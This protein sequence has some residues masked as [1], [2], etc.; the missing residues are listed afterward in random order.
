M[1]TWKDLRIGIKLSVGFGILL[2]LLGVVTFV[3]F[4]G[5]KK[6]SLAMHT[7]ADKDAPVVDVSMEMQRALTDAQTAMDEFMAATSVV[8]SDDEK[9]LS[10][11]EARYQ[12]ALGDFD[13][14][15]GAIM[16]GG[17]PKAG[18]VVQKTEDKELIQKITAADTL[19]NDKFQVAAGEL[20]KTGKALLKAKAVRA[21]AML[22]SEQAYTEIYNDAGGVE[23]MIATEMHKRMAADSGEDIQRF[24]SQL[25]MA[26]EIK[27]AIARTRIALEEYVQSVDPT[28]LDQLDKEYKGFISL[29]DT[30][31]GALLDGGTVD[32]Q[33]IA[34]LNEDKIRAAVSE[35]DQN[36]DV[37]QQAAANLMGA[38]RDILAKVAI[39]NKAMANFDRYGDEAAALLG[40]VE[41]YV[42]GE[43]AAAKASGAASEK[44]AVNISL[45]V[46]GFSLLLGLLLGFLIT[47]GITGPLGRGIG[48]AKAVSEGD[49]EVTVDLD[50][51]DEVGQLAS[52]LTVMVQQLRSIVLQV[53]QSADNVASGSEQLSASAQEMSQG[54]TEQA[55]SAEEISSS[56]EEMA[57]NINQNADNAAQTESIALKTAGDAEEGGKAVQDTVRAMKDIAEKI[58]IIEEI[59]R[60]TNLLALNAAIEAARAGEH[61]KGF[62]VVASEVRK[63]AERSQ[64]AAAEIGDLSSSSVQVAEQAGSLLETIAPDVKKTADLVQEITA[65][66]NEQRTG[67]DQVNGAIQQLDQVIQQN[68]GVAE[69]MASASEE[70]SAQAQ[71]LQE[72]MTYFKVHDANYSSASA[73]MVTETRRQKKH[74]QKALPE[75]PRPAAKRA[76]PAAQEGIT[77][78]FGDDGGGDELDKE[79]ERF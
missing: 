76:N 77:L 24:V 69:E 55:A 65:A 25:D 7:I 9:A 4:N 14:F 27:S 35:L 17:E 66:S 46:A 19:H 26:N 50:Q 60:Q 2:L 23:E 62:A 11:I 20:M 52:D 56:M 8:A 32:G 68:A 73:R 70:L 3:G 21:K 15:V 28:E 74:T 6:V 64:A 31:V 71:A 41:K 79:F 5:I 40:S 72:V 59:A 39:N 36:H 48:F 34:A 10:G 49:L 12:K 53:K 42:G 47:R 78:D 38:Q 63:L 18:L 51:Q 61:G 13:K 43:M 44:Q 45:L 37:F 30:L 57:A 75:A 54:A 22:A 58:S 1:T 33:K 67:A 16:E 29:F